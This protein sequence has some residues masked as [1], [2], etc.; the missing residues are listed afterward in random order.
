EFDYMF[1]FDEKANI[2]DCSENIDK[3]LG[4]NK[5]EMLHLNLSDFDLIEN[6]DD[7]E[8]K[9]KQIKKQGHIRVKTIHKRKNGSSV[10]VT[11]DIKYIK[12]KQMFQCTVKENSY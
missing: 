11:E 2:V 10:L 5:V 8:E 3:K 6:K 12:D 4:Y 1:L 7:I 9:I